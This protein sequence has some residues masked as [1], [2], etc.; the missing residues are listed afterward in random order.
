MGEEKRRKVR[1]AMAWAGKPR[2]HFQSL[3]FRW[4]NRGFG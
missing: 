2:T 4:Q 3:S 1:A